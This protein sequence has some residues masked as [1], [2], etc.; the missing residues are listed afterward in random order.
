MFIKKSIFHPT[1]QQRLEISEPDEDLKGAV[2]G[3]LHIYKVRDD[4]S[5]RENGCFLEMGFDDSDWGALFLG[6]LHCPVLG[7]RAENENYVEHLELYRKKFQQAIPLYP[8]LGRIWSIY[9]DVAYTHD[10][11]KQL[12][13]ECLAVQSST[14]D[15]HALRAL[16]KL[17][18]ACD[19]A[20]K[21]GMGL[22]LAGD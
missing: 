6:V 19:E 21:S 3:S 4:Q 15:P 11:V 16:R 1:S 12:Y 8:M 20:L 13:K 9:E 2:N 7:T 22:F 17:V 5:W 10:E 18:Y 14:T